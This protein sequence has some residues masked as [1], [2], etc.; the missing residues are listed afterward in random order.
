MS[1]SEIAFA[2][3]ERNHKL[4]AMRW[5]GKHLPAVI[6]VTDPSLPAW[7]NGYQIRIQTGAEEHANGD[8]T[9]K[10]DYFR[11]DADGVVKKAPRGWTPVYKGYTITGL[12]EAVAKYAEPAQEG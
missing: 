1:K 4:A 8:I 12:D 7:K 5:P 10:Y 3:I 2:V 9:R 6:R 11:L